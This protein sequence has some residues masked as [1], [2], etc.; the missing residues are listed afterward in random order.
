MKRPLTPLDF[1]RRALKLYPDRP[2]ILH[3]DL[4]LTYR[5]WGERLWRLVHALRAAGIRPGDHVAVLS[6]N[7]HEG[8]LAYAAVP[9]L[10]AVLVPLNT[11]LTPAEYRFQ[12]EFADVRL[13]LC[14]V[15][16]LD[17][18]QDVAAATGLITD[19]P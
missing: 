18:V 2:A 5:E 19:C 13:L 16:L 8:L 4:R 6:P 3:G 1:V 7:T 9:W 15:S 11:R 17:R 10:G 14:D 12:L